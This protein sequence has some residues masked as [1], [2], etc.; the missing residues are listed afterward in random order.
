MPVSR[1][2]GECSNL[3]P[4]ISWS[5]EQIKMTLQHWTPLFG[6]TWS[7]FTQTMSWLWPT[8]IPN[9]ARG[10]VQPHYLI[11]D[12]YCLHC[13]HPR[14]RQ[15]E[16]RSLLWLR[17]MGLSPRHLRPELSEMGD[18]RCGYP[19]FQV[20]HITF[21]CGQDQGSSSTGIGCSDNFLVSVQ[22]NPCHSS[23]INSAL[24]ALQNR[25]KEEFDNS[26]CTKLA[27][28]N[29]YTDILKLPNQTGQ[30]SQGPLLHSASHRP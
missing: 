14:S 16:C 20:Q 11:D 7:G 17:G 15:M 21:V 4:S 26:H 27:Q 22:A 23:S 30:Q 8:S 19:G 28:K 24:T 1:G 10:V 9:G 2:V 5:S 18:S 6:D 25:T 13:P 3:S 29:W 12:A